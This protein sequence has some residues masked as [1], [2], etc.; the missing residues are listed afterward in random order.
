[1]L[2]RG[3]VDADPITG[4]AS[5]LIVIDAAS[6]NSG[7]GARDQRMRESVLESD[8]YPEV[9]FSPKRVTGHLEVNGQFQAKLEGLLDLHGNRHE[10]VPDVRGQST[11]NQLVAS[12]HFSVPYVDWGMQDP[13]V[14][15]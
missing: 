12:S 15:S 6:G 8:K 11:G 1:M 9:T 4:A 13:S 7:I 10:V 3:V 2:K 5:G 14:F